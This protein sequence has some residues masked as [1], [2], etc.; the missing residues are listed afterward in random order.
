LCWGM[1]VQERGRSSNLMPMNLSSSITMLLY[2]WQ[3]FL[4]CSFPVGW[5][6]F[7]CFLTRECSLWKQR[8]LHKFSSKFTTKETENVS[9]YHSL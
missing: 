6:S 9:K 3:M 8:E 2:T 7:F 4:G 5:S 1:F